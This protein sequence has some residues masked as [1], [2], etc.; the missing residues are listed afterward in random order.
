MSSAPSKST[1]VINSKGQWLNGDAAASYLRMLA[2][3]CPVGGISGM[4]AGRTYAEQKQLYDLYRAGKG[5]LAAK[6]G[7]SLHEKG[8][9]LDVSRGTSAQL[10][11]VNGGSST[12]VKSGEK[13]RAHAYGWRRTVVSEAWHFEYDRARDTKRAAD[14][15]ARLAKLGYK[16]VKAFQ[17]AHKLTADG[18]DGPLTWAVLLGTPKPAPKPTPVPPKPKTATITVLVAN[19]HDPRFKGPKDSVAQGRFIAG[20]KPDII[21][22]S[23]SR[24]I[25]RDDIAAAMKS[26]NRETWKVWPSEAGTVG[27]LWDA[28]IFDHGPKLLKDFGDRYHGAVGS[29]LTVKAIKKKVRVISTHTC[30]KAVT[31][32]AGKKRDIQLAASLRS[33]LTLL[34]GDLAKNRPGSWLTGWHRLTPDTLDTMDAAG[35]Q[36][37]DSLWRHGSGITVERVALVNPGSLSDHRWLLVTLTI[38]A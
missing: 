32:D 34:G 29:D 12:A 10:W 22:A 24:P 7:T 15:K 16:D 36:S 1:V 9:A 35:H 21:L 38:T 37:P 4:G 26:R 33:G 31:T 20:L 17:R 6:P 2:A 8:N 23:E 28:A 3:G 11:M 25:D 19:L 14:L 30:P 27:L 5:N 13:L 18:V